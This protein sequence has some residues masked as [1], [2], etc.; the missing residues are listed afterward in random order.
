MVMIRFVLRF[1]YQNQKLR[2]Y[3][4]CTSTSSVSKLSVERRRRTFCVDGIVVDLRNN[5]T[6]KDGDVVIVWLRVNQ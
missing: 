4:I 6:W 1:V 5:I 2:K 3:D